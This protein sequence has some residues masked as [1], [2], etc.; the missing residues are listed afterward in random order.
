ME[1]DTGRDELRAT[2]HYT[3]P[4]ADRNALRDTLCRLKSAGELVEAAQ[5]ARELGLLPEAA[6]L[7]ERA[8]QPAQAAM[9]LQEAGR[10]EQAVSAL[11][12]VTPDEPHYT[13]CCRLAIDLAA[14][15]GRVSHELD[16]LL[17][18][19]V[20]DVKDR[21]ADRAACMRLGDLYRSQ[22][23]SDA[24]RRCYEQLL[25]GPDDAKASAR[26]QEL[27]AF[28][29]AF[30]TQ[31]TRASHE[32]LAAVRER[33]REDLSQ[34]PPNDAVAS[35]LPAPESPSCP[36]LSSVVGGRYRIEE[37]LGE[38]ATAVVFRASDLELGE[39]IAL[40]WVTSRLDQAGEARLR[41]EIS[42]TR[43]LAHPHVVRVHDLCVTDAGRFITMELLRGHD[44]SDYLREERALPL[45]PLDIL[46]QLLAGLQ[47]AHEQGVVHRDIKPEN[48]F[49]QADGRLKITDFGIAKAQAHATVTASNMII[50]TPMYIAPEQVD[51]V[52]N[53]DHRA[54]IYA[55][56]VIAYELVAGVLPFVDDTLVGLLQKQLTQPP[57]PPSQ[58]NQR[59]GKPLEELI[60]AMLEKR[61][62]D[63][64][65]SC[66][67][68]LERLEA[69]P[70]ALSA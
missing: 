44:L 8:Q 27:E 61:P 29:Q 26:L 10:P 46:R 22:G 67:E 36:E 11:A 59:L 4:A 13:A 37:R 12:K 15:C 70:D 35:L 68:V 18:A 2:L 48:L 14:E 55:A 47:Y 51:D 40:K 17:S 20:R 52:K 39:D 53:V 32:D 23:F 24:A 60:L 34:P 21:P 1:R 57:I 28:C 56:G 31:E 54:D 50:G 5:A 45:G 58:Y 64:P 43:K 42:V 66:G 7:F 65:Q 38:G 19:F 33:L 62:D 6:S 3:K 49:L 30:A 41:R 69:L 25:A 16:E 9:C 63:R